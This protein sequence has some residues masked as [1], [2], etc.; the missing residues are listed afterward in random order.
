MD[1]ILVSIPDAGKALGIGRSKI[2]EL[3]N[4][5]DLQ[6]VTIGRRRLVC[7]ESVKAFATKT[8]EA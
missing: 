1:P 2:Y 5:G 4:S 8:A 3:L 6:T 7:V